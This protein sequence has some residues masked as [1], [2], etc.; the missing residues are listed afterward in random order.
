MGLPEAEGAR[1][2]VREGHL[3]PRHRGGGC[4][5]APR[6]E[7]GRKGDEGLYRWSVFFNAVAKP[8]PRLTSTPFDKAVKMRGKGTPT[9]KI[10]GTALVNR[11]LRCHSSQNGGTYSGMHGVTQLLD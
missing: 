11:T 3:E 4:R 8:P 2:E 5:Q 10:C 1:G 7:G 6:E 9:K